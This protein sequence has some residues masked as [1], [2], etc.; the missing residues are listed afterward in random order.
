M[1]RRGYVIDIA[2]LSVQLVLPPVVA[3]AAM[4][5]R[6]AQRA[7]ADWGLG[8]FEETVLLLTTELVSNGV[9]HAMTTMTLS[10]SYDGSCLRVAVSDQNH[11]IPTL[12]P[13]YGTRVH[14]W[15]LRLVDLLASDWGTNVEA[16]GK[17]VWFELPVADYPA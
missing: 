9:Q 16:G 6:A 8:R 17:T 1:S 11:D 5:R 10:I 4:A 12:A 15:G 7:L 14:G 13:G 2:D 3:S